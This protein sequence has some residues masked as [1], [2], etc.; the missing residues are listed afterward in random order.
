M[1][2]IREMLECAAYTGYSMCSADAGCLEID[3]Q[4][5]AMRPPQHPYLPAPPGKPSAER[6]T[7]H[8]YKG[9]S[10]KRNSHSHRITIGPWA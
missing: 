1:K 8:G 10:L 9:T 3:Y 5:L 4:S 6:V 2:S 7:G